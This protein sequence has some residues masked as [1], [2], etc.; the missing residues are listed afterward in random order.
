MADAIQITQGVRVRWVNN[1]RA[2]GTVTGFTVHGFA[3]VEFRH[4]DAP[5]TYGE[6]TPEELEIENGDT[7]PSN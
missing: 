1:P 5:S 4:D 2:V 7:N 6:F 3:V